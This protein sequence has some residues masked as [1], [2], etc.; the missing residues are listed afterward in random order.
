MPKRTG[1]RKI[2]QSRIFS[3][4][5]INL[6]FDSGQKATYDI[7]EGG[8]GAMVVPFLD[9]DT[10]LFVRE[11][12]AARDEYQLGLCKGGIKKGKTPE[13]TAIQELQEEVG[14]TAK[15]LDKLGIFTIMPGY[16]AD[17]T[18]LFL[19]RE[20]S[21]SKLQGD[22]VEELEVIPYSFDRFEELIDKGEIK[23]ARVISA[24]YL[25][26]RFLERE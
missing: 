9:K 24:L 6:E 11:Y 10:I 23:E 22:E 25:A 4:K 3:V 17:R 16:L 13:E 12:H 5:E 8:D 1:E 18:H 2:F 19:A 15:R 26:K 14:Y 7:I 21:P 20:L